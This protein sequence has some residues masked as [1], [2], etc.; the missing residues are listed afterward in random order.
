M[1]RMKGLPA[2]NINQILDSVEINTKPQAM[3]QCSGKMLNVCS[4]IMPEL[5]GGSAD[6]S[7]SNCVLLENTS[8]YT[9]Q[10]REGRFLHYGIREHSMSAIS[11]GM[12]CHGGIRPFCSTFFSFIQYMM[13]GVRM[14]AI[15]QSPVLYIMTHDSIGVGEDGPTHQPIE[16]L[17]QIRCMPNVVLLRPADEKET[18]GAYKS[19]EIVNY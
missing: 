14:S 17:A 9:P 11:N 2:K 18:L 12:W 13:N 7:A 8:D 4:K 10:C 5:V 6:L 19:N 15:N 16:H 1:R 3:R